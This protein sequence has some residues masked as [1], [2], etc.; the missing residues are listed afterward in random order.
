MQ[1]TKD[2]ELNEGRRVR[3]RLCF[4]DTLKQIPTEKWYHWETLSADRSEW[5]HAVNSGT[6]L[7]ETERRK[8]QQ[9]YVFNM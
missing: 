1:I 3:R 8:K 7:Y 9:Q 2:K 4:K 6:Q 5:R